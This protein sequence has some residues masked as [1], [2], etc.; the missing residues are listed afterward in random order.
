MDRPGILQSGRRD[1]PAIL[2]LHGIGGAAR[3]WKPQVARFAEAGYRALALDLPGYGA[4]SPV[5]AMRFEDLASDVERAVDAL[6]LAKPILVGHSMGGMIAQTALRRRP[7]GY[8]AAILVGTSPA[9]G[10]P[11]GDFQKKFV[12][13]RLGPLDGGKT[14]PELAPSMV[15]AMMG[16]APD[17]AGHALALAC[18]SATPEST[19]RA[20]V[21]CLVEFDERANL[22][23]IAIPV[24]CLVGENDRNAPP[25]VSE[26]MAAKIP[27]GTYR[28]LPRLGHLPNLEA[29][30]VFDDAVLEFLAEKIARPKAEPALT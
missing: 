30:Q 11:A 3:A 5:T 28:C 13:D 4:R 10:N 24:L 7:S 21:H 16:P 27:D 23:A 8:A 29:P 2:F 26:K 20:A 19:Y 17:A 9:F 6:A 1:A 14:L 18:M 22:P 15:D 25:I 12:M